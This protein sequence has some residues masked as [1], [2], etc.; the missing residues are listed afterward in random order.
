MGWAERRQLSEPGS[1]LLL[2]SAIAGAR[3]TGLVEASVA[4]ALSAET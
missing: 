1:A 3:V 4:K 2:L